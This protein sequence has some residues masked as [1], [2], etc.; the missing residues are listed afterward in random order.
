MRSRVECADRV[1]RYIASIYR[2]EYTHGERRVDITVV[3][4]DGVEP[5]RTRNR[6]GGRR[7]LYSGAVRQ[8]IDYTLARRAVLRDL[9]TRHGRPPRRV[10]RPPRAPPGRPPR[11][12]ARARTGARCAR[13]GTS[14]TSRTS[15]ATTC[16]RRT[17]A[18][19]STRASSSASTPRTRSTPATWWR[20]APTAGGTS[21]P[22]ASCTAAARVAPPRR[23]AGRRARRR[24]CSIVPSA[25][26]S[27]GC[28]GRWRTD[29]MAARVRLPRRAL[30]APDVVA[31]KGSGTPLVMVTAY[32]A[33]SAPRGRR[34]R[35]RHDPRR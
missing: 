14:A 27:R 24:R 11:R 10:R 1:R 23:R 31:R 8:H 13:P 25:A 28:P 6:G 4:G 20:C 2:Y 5:G 18:A 32:D 19:S 34:R 29:E 9:R 15:T 7:P 22:A 33:P 35:R 26:G 3:P 16:A 17:V 30:G 12:R 21:S